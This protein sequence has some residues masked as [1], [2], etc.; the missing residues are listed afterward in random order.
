MSNFMRTVQQGFMVQ[1]LD[2]LQI[3]VTLNLVIYTIRGFTAVHANIPLVKP[4]LIAP[5][6]STIGVFPLQE[7]ME[8]WSAAPTWPAQWPCLHYRVRPLS[9]VT[10]FDQN[11]WLPRQVTTPFLDGHNDWEEKRHLLGYFS[12][13]VG[14][15]ASSCPMFSQSVPCK[16]QTPH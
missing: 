7:F 6:N 2:I 3:Q 8:S 5:L 11:R 9:H 10:C 13:S 14:F 16:S 15:Q 1:I 4:L 12:Y